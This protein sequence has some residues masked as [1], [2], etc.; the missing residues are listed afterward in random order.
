ME[1]RFITPAQPLPF[2]RLWKDFPAGEVGRATLYITGLGLYRAWLNGTRVGEDFLT[3]GW[4]DYDAYLRYQAYDVTGLLRV[5]NHLEVWLGQGWY[6]GRLGTDGG[7]ENIWGDRYLLAA[8][9]EVVGRD[10][11]VTVVES[12]ESW[13]AARSNIVSGNIYDGE[14]RD[15]TLE[16]GTP[17]PCRR[18]ETGYRLVGRFSPPV[19]VQAECKPTLCITPKGER[20]LDFGQNM[21]GIIR[22][23]GR[24]P[25]GATMRIQAG[26]V[27]QGGCFYRDNL[28]TARAEFI[29]TSDGQEK[30]VEPLFTFFGFRYARVEGLETVRAEDF[31][32]LALSCD[33]APTLRVETGH[34]KINQLMRNA[35]WGQRSNFLDVPTDC[36]QRDE[37][38]GW[39]ADAQVF[40]NTAC[41]QMDCKAFYRKYM[42]DLRA[43]QMLY[44]DGDVPMYCPSL[45]GTARPGGAVWADA[46]TIIPWNIYMHYGDAALL[47]ETYPLMRDY[48]QRLIDADRTLGGTHVRFDRFTFGDWLAQDGMTPQS[49]KGG[50]DDAFI[51][52][53]YYM[54]SV[55]LTGRAARALGKA[56]E[57]QAYAAL[58]EGIRGALLDE[59]VSPAGNLTVDTQTGYA[60]A[61]YFDLYRNR[62]KLLYGFR[63][64]LQR[65]FYRI[66]CGFTGTPLMLPALLDNGMADVAF[67]LLLSEQF[68]GWLY[69][70][71][72]GATTIWERW[73]SLEADGRISGTGMNSLNHYAYGAVCEAIY[74][75]IIGLANAAPGWT[76][77]RV[78]PHLD[79]RLRFA[80]LAFEAPSGPWQL[81]WEIGGD[82][83]ITLSLRV[84]KGAQADVALPEHPQALQTTVGAGEYTW[85]WQPTR[86]L[87]H[88]FSVAGIV[89]DLL[90]NEEAAALL[91]TRVPA[92]YGLVANEG[93]EFR[94]MPL[95]D[96][97]RTMP[98]L[99]PAAVM[100]LDPA[101]RR[102]HI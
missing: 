31:T 90:D 50:T 24:L 81:G 58:A 12:D 22:F 52:G 83:T 33:L 28:R 92:L 20:V 99:D 1:L 67:R 80:R 101:L 95:V 97:S 18:V 82:G 62:E 88:P 74:S 47:A 6:M 65:D 85:H 102:I 13:L 15:D 30:A 4:N 87:L 25:R 59:Y 11:R 86:D 54:H 77:A 78:A 17:L 49:L 91:R 63:R 40:V 19:R 64:R 7:R 38:L 45:K 29:Y 43:E 60:L 8:R 37:R 14:V 56:G 42:R 35:F 10:G 53:I 100:A 34:A 5:Q 96:V 2:P 21:A 69:A 39:T 57:A 68:P 89:E 16:M 84:P 32:A 70:V 79:A 9:L 55:D 26:E 66:T 94:V 27:L 72:L 76:R 41:Y 61:L 23:T 44:Y 71:N 75:R 48:T 3:P 73:N 36:P 98:F 46:A 51:Q 93:S